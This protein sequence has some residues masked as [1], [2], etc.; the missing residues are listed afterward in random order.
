MTIKQLCERFKQ[1][2]IQRI[3]NDERYRFIEPML[4]A[5]GYVRESSS[6]P[7]RI[8]WRNNENK[9]VVALE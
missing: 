2:R 1:W 9:T 3:L 4:I 5:H 7:R 8:S 6:T